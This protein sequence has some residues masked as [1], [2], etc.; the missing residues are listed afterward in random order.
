MGRAPARGADLCHRARRPHVGRRTDRAPS[1]AQRSVVGPVRRRRAARAYV[2]LACAGAI[3]IRPSACPFMG[4]QQAGRPGSVHAGPVVGLARRQRVEASRVGMGSGR[5]GLVGCP[6]GFRTERAP[7][8]RAVMERTGRAGMGCAQDPGAR[9]SGRAIVVGPIGCTTAAAGTAAT[10]GAAVCTAATGCTAATSAAGAATLRRCSGVVAA[11]RV[12]CPA[13]VPRASHGG[14]SRR[15]GL[16]TGRGSGAGPSA[17]AVARGGPTRS[18]CPAGPAGAR[19]GR[20]DNRAGR[21]RS[22]RRC[23]R[24]R[25]HCPDAC[26]AT[27]TADSATSPA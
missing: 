23:R 20:H 2:G 1:R 18:A 8:Q 21:S 13:E 6:W 14:T 15:D 9:R 3:A 10:G 27:T 24:P 11:R 19:C 16:A 12:S 22:G 17:V 4:R 26:V 25:R 5:A 7:G